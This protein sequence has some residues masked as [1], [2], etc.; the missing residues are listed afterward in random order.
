MKGIRMYAFH[1]VSPQ[2]QLVGAYF[3]IDLRIG[4][5]FS[6]AAHTD[7]LQHTIDYGAVYA[8]LEE[9]MQTPSK[10]L[11]HVAWR[12]ASHLFANFTAIAEVEV[13]VSKENP[14]MGAEASLVGVSAVFG[15]DD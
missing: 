14:P 4:V 10:L 1:G 8:M 3:T 13:G 11:E 7:Q 9:V 12:I 2:E 5:D 15:R 6:Q